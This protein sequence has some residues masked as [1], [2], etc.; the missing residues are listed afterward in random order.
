MPAAADATLVLLRS[1]SQT[2]E[3]HRQRTHE[4]SHSLTHSLNLAYSPTLPL[5][6][7]TLITHQDLSVQ[8]FVERFERPRLPV[9]ITGLTEE[10]AA[11]Q[12]AWDPDQLAAKYGE[13]KFKVGVPFIDEHQG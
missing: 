2:T 9:V 10:W 11:G 6:L 3:W 12:G 8:E 4:R 1:I 5:T 7:I 13:H